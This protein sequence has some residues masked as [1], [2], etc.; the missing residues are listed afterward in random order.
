[1]WNALQ[2][3]KGETESLVRGYCGGPSSASGNGARR[4]K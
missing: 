1:M 4:V 2:G 3:A